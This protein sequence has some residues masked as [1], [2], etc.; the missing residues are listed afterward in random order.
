MAGSLELELDNN[1]DVNKEKL[2]TPYVPQKLEFGVKIESAPTPFNKTIIIKI[3]P[4]YVIVNQLQKPIIIKQK[5]E[6]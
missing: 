4:R 3:L 5:D 6:Q 1:R 2:N